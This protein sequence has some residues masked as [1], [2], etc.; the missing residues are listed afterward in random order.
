ML[1]EPLFGVRFGNDC[2]DFDTG[3][4]GLQNFPELFAPV[5]TAN[6]GI[7][8]DA[9]LRSSPS[10]PFTIDFY[11][12]NAADPSNYGEGGALDHRRTRCQ[13][14]QRPIRE[15]DIPSEDETARPRDAPLR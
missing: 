3:A 8:V 1:F 12:N 9:V 10:Q 14:P 7:S 4:N 15:D 13:P 5:P 6:G 2:Q 11:S